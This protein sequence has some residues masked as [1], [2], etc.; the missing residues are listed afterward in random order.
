M[1]TRRLTQLALAFVAAAALYRLWPVLAG[2]PALSRAFLTEDGYL[3]LTVARNMATGL[4]MTVSDGTIPTNG[5]QPLATFLFAGAY[6]VAGGDRV[7]GLVGVHAILAAAALGGVFALR[8]LARRLLAGLHDDP[9]WPW[10]AAALWFAGPLLVFHT[11]NGLETGL[12]TLLILLSL[13]QFARVLE[14]GRAAG[15]APGLL[16]GGALGLAFLARIDTVFLGVAVYAIWALHL[17]AAQ[18]LTVGEAA[19]RILPAGLL[20]VA[21]SAPWLVANVLR[22]GEIMPTSGHSQQ[23]T[24]GF[25]QNLALLPAKLFEHAVPVLPVPG[26]LER[27]PA[28]MAATGL[29]VGAALAWFFWRRLR[30]GGAICWV[31]LAYLAHGAALAGYYGMV[32]G[33]PH[34]LGRYLAPLAPLLIVAVLTGALDL[35]RALARERAARI[36]PALALAGL[37]LSAALL[38]WRA[39]P[40]ARPQGHFQ[41]VEWV[42][43]NVDDATWVAAVQTGTLGYWHDRTI[44]LDGK[45]NPAALAARRAHGSVLPYVVETGKIRYIVDWA[46]MA[47]WAGRPDGGFDR[48]FELVVEDPAADLAVLR[49]RDPAG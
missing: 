22:F 18:R 21:L 30:A 24:A 11:M 25:G 3:M 37:V 16:L 41:V 19:R 5:V 23:L 28:V 1:T 33:A 4:G 48:A 38:G 32:F 31:A 10:A 20:T 29:V 39:G 43:H 40:A 35:V 12:V 13:L 42:K 26:G 46:G 45:V 49:R 14:R 15:P 17:I 2:Q 36:A 6:L 27:A 9:A 34:F 44:N 8:A 7:A 47:G